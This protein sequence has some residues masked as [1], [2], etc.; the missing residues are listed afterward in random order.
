MTN[1]EVTTQGKLRLTEIDQRDDGG[2]NILTV[3]CDIELK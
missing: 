3:E 1:Y 2:I